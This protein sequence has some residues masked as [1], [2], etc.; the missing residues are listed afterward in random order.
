MPYARMLRNILLLWLP[1]P[2]FVPV[3]VD[4]PNS[5]TLFRGKRDFGISAIIVGLVATAAVAASITA[6]ALALSTTVQTTQTI[7]E[8]SMIVTTALDKQATAN[9]QIQGGLMLINQRIDLVQEQVDILW[10]LAQLGCECKMPGLCVTSV[11]FENST[12][13]ANLSKTLSRY[14]LQNW[15]MEFEQTL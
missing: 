10:Q 15:T 1:M 12:R 4:A 2:R 13:A 3:P 9:S 8:L 6:S 14:M 7:N 11:Q 5:L